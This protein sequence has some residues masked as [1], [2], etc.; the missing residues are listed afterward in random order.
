[1]GFG[2]TNTDNAISCG[3]YTGNG[4]TAGP[5][6]T[7]G[8]EPQWLMIKNA[9]GTGNWRIVDNVRGMPVGTADASLQANLLNSEASIDHVSPTATGFQV[10]TT[11][12]EVNTLN[13]TYLYMAI[14]RGPMRVPTTGTSVLSVKNYA[15]TTTSASVTHDVTFD[16]EINAN[17]IR[18]TV[19]KFLV[20]DTLRGIN[21]TYVW[22]ATAGGEGSYPAYWSR[23]GQRGMSAVSSFDGWW[24]SDSGTQNHISYGLVRA[25][26]FFDIVC[27]TGTGGAHTVTHNLKAIPGLMLRKS[28]SATS[29]WEV[30]CSALLNTEKLVLNTS[31][32]KTTDT[33]AWNSTTPTSGVFT[34][35]TG[36]TVNTSGATYVTYLFATCPGVS[37]VGSFTGTAATQV[38]NCGFTSGARLVLI[39][40]ISAIGDW[41][42]F[43]TTRG[44][45]A[46]TDPYLLV[47]NNA[48]AEVTTTDWIDPAASG[49]ELS[50]SAGNLVNSSGVTYIYLAIS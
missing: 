34:V 5:N 42:I 39:K 26:G 44:I 29:A 25:P 24:A 23:N 4:L 30:Y 9:S 11:S 48:T 12:S 33:T 10:T 3:S 16:A 35:G 15:A 46:G 49:F 27:D 38:I 40:S 20:V 43:D 2:P 18:T 41:Y 19:A 21:G 14:R 7:L 6:I 36:S 37:S 31:A 28:R 17:R 1:M 32:A 45:V 22:T 13:A 47:N 50:N 8:Y